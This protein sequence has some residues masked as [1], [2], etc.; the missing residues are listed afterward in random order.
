MTLSASEREALDAHEAVIERGLQ[1]FVAVGGALLAIR[2]GRLYRAQYPTWEAY[3]Q[4]RWGIKRSYA[5]KLIA[6]AELADGLGT[7]VPSEGVARALRQ[8]PDD[9]RPAIAQIAAAQAQALS[10]PLSAGMV[11]RVGT[12]V[13][14]AARTG[15]VD[16]NG[17]ATPLTAAL[18]DEEYEALARQLQHLADSRPAGA[19]RAGGTV[20]ESDEAYVYVAVPAADATGLRV[21]MDVKVSWVQGGD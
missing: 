6:A 20:I 8:F 4:A 13:L 12:V 10:A 15:A 17:A 14:Q 18:T 2:D 11:A 3:C 9:L 21:G 16:V 7:I 19:T 1:T 5:N